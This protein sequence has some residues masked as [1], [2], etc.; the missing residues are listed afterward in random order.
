LM[1]QRRFVLQPLAEIAPKVMHPTLRMTALA[2]L[3]ALTP[4]ADCLLPIAD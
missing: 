2:L 3:H 4:I 1:H